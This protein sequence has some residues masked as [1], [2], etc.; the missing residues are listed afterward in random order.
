[1]NK[2]N[3]ILNVGIIIVFAG[4][5]ILLSFGTMI[6][7]PSTNKIRGVDMTT[8]D[9]KQLSYYEKAVLIR[10][11]CMKRLENTV[12]MDY[13][14]ESLFSENQI[15]EFADDLQKNL[16]G[17]THS[18]SPSSEL[19]SEVVESLRKHILEFFGT[20]ISDYSVVFT[21][22]HAQALKVVAEA[23][24]FDQKSCFYMAESSSNN[25]LGLRGFAKEK[26]ANVD[27]FLI[28]NT[29]S[30]SFQENSTNLISLPLMNEFDGSVLSDVEISK[31]IGAQSENVFT[32]VDASLYTTVRKLNLKNTPFS[33]VA[34]S[35]DRLFGYPNIGAALIHNSFIK[36]LQ[37]PYFG[38]GTLVYALTKS[39]YEKLRIKPSEKFEDGS[40]PFLSICSLKY[41]FSQFEH[42]GWEDIH[43]HIE[44]MGSILRTKIGNI[45]YLNGSPATKVY[46]KE[47]VSIITFSIIDKNGKLL[48]LDQLIKSAKSKGIIFSSGCMSTPVSCIKQI[49]DENTKGAIR[50]SIGW[51]TTNDDIDYVVSFIQSQITE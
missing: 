21:Y 34:I 51:V 42:L 6:S 17:N 1:M 31:I 14:T 7:A 20:T 3:N 26:M 49:G 39:N 37:R 50:L 12:Y 11:Q 38:G 48:D 24:P 29:D 5:V 45:R 16:Y 32:L 25:I 27:N 28:E 9:F 15:S 41:G 2:V 46:G 40:L 22:S 23:F 44:K 43:A 18:E 30:L 47:S 8:P 35:F 33:A 36:R 10:K 19:S 4:I 13:A